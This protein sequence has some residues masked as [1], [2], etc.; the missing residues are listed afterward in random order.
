MKRRKIGFVLRAGSLEYDDRVRKECCSLSQKFDITIFVAFENN[1]E[2]EGVTSYGIPYKS[3]RL[4]TR[5]YLKSGKYLFVKAFEFYWKVRPHLRNYDIVWAH[6]EYTFI[7]VLL[8]NTN[9]LI[10]DLHEIPDRFNRPIL[11]N[12]FH[13]IER[14]CLRIIHGNQYRFEYLKKNGLVIHTEKHTFLRNYPDLNFIS[15]KLENPSFTSIFQWLKDQPFVYLQG[16]MNETRYPSNTLEA[17]ITLTDYKIVVVGSMNEKYLIE[18]LIKKFGHVFNERIY[19][20]GMLNQLETPFL[21]KKSI[22][23][24]IFYQVNTPNERYCE[25]NRFYQSLALGIPVI[26]GCNEP[27]A[28]I[29][30]AYNCGVNLKGDG[31]DIADIKNAISCFVEGY[32]K[33]KN[34]AELVKEN[35]IWSDEMVLKIVS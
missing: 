15:S 12:V 14:R 7:F 30:S 24:M 6:E 28:E 27:M 10:W 11:R 29:I 3:F 26:T 23:S 31:S 19:F 13:I 25:A 2:E 17:L 4:R 21:L 9:L 32:R 20:T 5:E 34:N 16:I 22:F 8:L 1:K 18:N 35:F 33:F